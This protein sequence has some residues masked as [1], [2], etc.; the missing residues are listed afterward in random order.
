MLTDHEAVCH[1]LKSELGF[2]PIHNQVTGRVAGQA[3]DVEAIRPRI[4]TMLRAQK[5]ERFF[6]VCLDEVARL[7]WREALDYTGGNRSRAAKLLGISRPTLHAK[8]EK[9]DLGNPADTVVE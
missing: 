8:I 3:S 7:R 5:K 6:D 9:Y 4:R 2:R 1:S